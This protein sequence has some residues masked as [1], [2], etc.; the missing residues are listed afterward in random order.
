MVRMQ[1]ITGFAIIAA[2]SVTSSGDRT[3]NSVV[4]SQSHESLSRT[5]DRPYLLKRLGKVYKIGFHILFSE[6]LLRALLMSIQGYLYMISRSNSQT[7][8][9][10]LFFHHAAPSTRMGSLKERW[11]EFKAT[12]VGQ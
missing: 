12:P 11:I 10:G 4:G 8:Q 9:A 2:L 5:P 3:R 7:G 1:C 6:Y